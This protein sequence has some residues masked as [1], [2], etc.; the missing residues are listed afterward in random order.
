LAQQAQRLPMVGLI[1]HERGGSVDPLGHRS[2]EAI[3]QLG[4]DCGGV[5]KH[6]EPRQYIRV[7]VWRQPGRDL[8]NAS[9][10]KLGQ[11]DAGARIDWRQLAAIGAAIDAAG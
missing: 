8:R 7:A 1:A 2:A 5:A 4:H 6:V 10:D 3:V 9:D 11:Y